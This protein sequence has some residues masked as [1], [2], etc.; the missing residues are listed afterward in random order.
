M[1]SAKATAATKVQAVRRGQLSRQQ[2]FAEAC[3][4]EA[5]AD[6]LA[7]KRLDRRQ[8]TE[9]R[10]T[11]KFGARLSSKNLN[12]SAMKVHG[13]MDPQA[14]IFKQIALGASFATNDPEAVSLFRKL[15]GPAQYDEFGE[16]ISVLT[17]IPPEVAPP[18]ILA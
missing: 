2:T 13:G 7:D 6:V 5:E 15:D 4:E 8:R 16:E 14:E 18:P 9:T 11:Q 10:L 3:A 12:L 17:R 1:S